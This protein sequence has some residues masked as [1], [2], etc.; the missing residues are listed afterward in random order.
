MCRQVSDYV[1]EIV[2]TQAL[3]FT[4]FG[5]MFSAFM[6]ERRLAPRVQPNQ[7]QA[8]NWEEPL[9]SITIHQ[10]AGLPVAVHATS[11]VATVSS[12]LL[13]SRAAVTDRRSYGQRAPW[14]G[15]GAWPQ[16][17]IPTQW[18]QLEQLACY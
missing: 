12:R 11:P 10:A 16:V 9:L 1:R 14:G 8:S 7:E 4:F 6:P 5:A 3:G 15:E 18:H 2:V 13:Q 17:H